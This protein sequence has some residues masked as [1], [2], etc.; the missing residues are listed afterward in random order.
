MNNIYTVYWI[1]LILNIILLCL[2]DRLNEN[3][4]WNF[5]YAFVKHIVY[6]IKLPILPPP[7]PPQ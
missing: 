6:I 4:I 3:L 5:V 2:F 1:Y 7:P